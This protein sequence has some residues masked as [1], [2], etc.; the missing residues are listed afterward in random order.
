MLAPY[1][2]A[3]QNLDLQHK[4]EA[5]V[6]DRDAIFGKYFDRIL[7]KEFGVDPITIGFKKPWQQGKIERYHLTLKTEI[8]SRIPISDVAHARQ[9][10]IDFQKF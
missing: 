4:I 5:L 10:C 6:H 9:L 1:F 3:I 8:L 7:L 2:S